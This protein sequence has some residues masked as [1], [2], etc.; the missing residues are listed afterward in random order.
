MLAVILTGGKGSRVAEIS[1]GKPKCLIEVDGTTVLE[2]QLRCLEKCDFDEVVIISGYGHDQIINFL[3]TFNS[4]LKISVRRDQSLNG[5]LP[6]LRLILDLKIEFF[7]LVYGDI[8]FDL[9]LAD[10]VNYHI[11]KKADITALIHNSSHIS[12]SDSLEI[13]KSNKIT[14]VKLKGRN[15][16]LNSTLSLGGIYCINLKVLTSNNLNQNGDIVSNLLE[17]LVRFNQISI[18]GYKNYSFCKD[19]GTPERLKWTEKMKL[20]EMVGG[21]HRSRPYIFLDRDGTI[22]EDFEKKIDYKLFKLKPLVLEAIKF[23]SDL[24]YGIFIVTNQPGIA[25]GYISEDQVELI[26]EKLLKQI[27][28]AGG[29]VDD[30]FYCPHH[31]DSGFEGEVTKLKVECACRKPNSGLV[32]SITHKVNI[33]FNGSWVVGDTWRDQYL[34][35]N[36]KTNFAHIQSTNLILKESK[37][38]KTFGSLWDFSQSLAQE[39]LRNH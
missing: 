5:T 27:M 19:I 24:G 15:D 22:N 30:I 18:Y 20:H 28:T 32:D 33:D 3:D 31:P 23:I 7:I 14:K 35:K 12:D 16:N 1:P 39:Y 25:K 26:H 37:S 38:E 9:N 36:L 21:W 8:V 10:F 2:H 4:S 6:A 13:D 34:A 29:K 17:P 11:S